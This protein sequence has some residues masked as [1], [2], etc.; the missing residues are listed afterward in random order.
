MRSLLADRFLAFYRYYRRYVLWFYGSI[1][2]GLI[3]LA[4][5]L[6][7][8]DVELVGIRITWYI[9]VLPSASM[10]LVVAGAMALEWWTRYPVRGMLCLASTKLHWY[11]VNDRGDF[12]SVAKLTLDNHAET[13]VKELRGER[14]GFHVFLD[15]LRP[16]YRPVGDTRGTE[17]RFLEKPTAHQKKN[18]FHGMERV[19]HTWEWSLELVPPLPPGRQLD[20]VRT[21][22]VK[23]TEANAFKEEGTYAAW[24][25]LYP[26][27]QLEI[28]LHVPPGYRL[29][30]LDWGMVDEIGAELSRHR[31][32]S[33]PPSLECADTVLRWM[34]Y[35]PKNECRYTLRYRARHMYGDSQ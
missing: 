11:L 14:E 22:D 19:V 24:T 10:V 34:I 33:L 16:R 35:Y 17:V 26:T 1:F 12:S 32:A 31:R 4:V 6:L 29:E 21:L 2:C 5:D 20:L 25:I 18:L 13:V 27:R 7:K 8:L 9:K 30:L 23:G 28:Y 15:S 3:A